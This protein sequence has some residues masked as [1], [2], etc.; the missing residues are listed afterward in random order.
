ME[1]F[2]REPLHKYKQDN[3]AKAKYKYTPVEVEY[4]AGII[5]TSLEIRRERG[6]RQPSNLHEYMKAYNEESIE[7]YNDPNLHSGFL[8]LDKNDLDFNFFKEQFE[9]LQ[10][11]TDE[12][13]AVLRVYTGP[14]GYK[15]AGLLHKHKGNPEVIKEDILDY[16]DLDKLVKYFKMIRPV[17]PI[18]RNKHYFHSLFAPS[19]NN[20]NAYTAWYKQKYQ[21]DEMEKKFK[22]EQKELYLKVAIK[23]F[24]VLNNIFQKAPT[25]KKQIRVFRGIKP[26]DTNYKVLVPKTKLNFSKRENYD[27]HTRG[28]YREYDLSIL[29]KNYLPNLF[30]GFV[31]TTYSPATAMKDDFIALTKDSFYNPVTNVY[32]PKEYCCVFDIVVKPGV[33]ALWLAPIS[34]I[35]TTVAYNSSMFNRINSPNARDNTEREIVLYCNDYVKTTFSQPRMKKRLEYGTH[36]YQNM[37]YRT[38]DVVIEPMSIPRRPGSRSL[39][40]PS[41][42]IEGGTRKRRTT[43]KRKSRRQ[44]RK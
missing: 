20:M 18:I 5:P 4:M 31:S 13:L 39:V 14:D 8:Y 21:R 2:T 23:Y 3:L 35:H 30:S 26:S 9:F 29:S 15:I 7:V 1:Q 19:M 34:D 44:V 27:K 38:Y 41:N 6:E 17:D 43:Q 12:E 25:V 42:T 33:K 40:V 28:N 32:K 36:I 16:P 10:S 37:R 22:E 24:E 11:L